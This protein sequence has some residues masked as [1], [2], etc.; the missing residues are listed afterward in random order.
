[1]PVVAM[2]AIF[3]VMDRFRPLRPLEPFPL[4]YHVRN[5]RLGSRHVP[6]VAALGSY[7][8]PSLYLHM[9]AALVKINTLQWYIGPP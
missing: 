1:M 4:H 2:Q 6:A 8:L 3:H 9:A 7:F 5:M